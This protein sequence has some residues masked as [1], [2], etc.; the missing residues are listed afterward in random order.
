MGRVVTQVPRPLLAGPG[1]WEASKAGH[2]PLLASLPLA[3]PP[4]APA[5]VLGPSAPLQLSLFRL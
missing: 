4:E 1:L 5:A 2:F 3:P